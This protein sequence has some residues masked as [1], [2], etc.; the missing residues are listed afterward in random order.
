L[1]IPQSI[2]MIRYFIIVFLTIFLARCSSNVP[3]LQY[4]KEM[5]SF[6]KD[7]ARLQY[8]FDSVTVDAYDDSFYKLAYTINVV[9]VDSVQDSLSLLVPLIITEDLLNV[10]GPLKANEQAEDVELLTASS[11]NAHNYYIAVIT[12]EMLKR[13]MDTSGTAHK[14]PLPFH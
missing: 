3:Y 4:K 5:S 14:M 1:H 11:R 2:T 12:Q 10:L 13:E 8:S 7:N 6:L 9:R